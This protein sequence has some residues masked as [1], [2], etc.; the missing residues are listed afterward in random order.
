MFSFLLLPFLLKRSGSFFVQIQ[1]THRAQRLDFFGKI[2]YNKINKKALKADFLYKT[3]LDYEKEKWIWMKIQCRSL[4]WTR[5][6]R[7]I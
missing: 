4:P 7:K 6:D 2:V 5:L 1:N 3:P